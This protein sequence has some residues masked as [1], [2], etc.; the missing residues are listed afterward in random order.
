MSAL[1]QIRAGGGEGR[2]LAVAGIALGIVGMVFGAL[3]L[4]LILLGS[5]VRSS[6]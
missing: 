4:L 1:G 5:V 2:G 3:V 6:P